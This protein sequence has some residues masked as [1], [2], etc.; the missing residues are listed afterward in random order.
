VLVNQKYKD[1]LAVG[2]YSRMKIA[3]FQGYRRQANGIK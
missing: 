2:K 1:D 3:V